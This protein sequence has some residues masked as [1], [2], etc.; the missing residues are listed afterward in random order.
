MIEVV[1]TFKG[2][3]RP[4]SCDLV[5][6]LNQRH[7]AKQLRRT[8]REKGKRSTSQHERSSFKGEVSTGA[9][10]RG[11]IPREGAASAA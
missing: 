7:A 11:T 8:S 2:A 10:E 1:K 9:P 4:C 5:E 3:D 6:V